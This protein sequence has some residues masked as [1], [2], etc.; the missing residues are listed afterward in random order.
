MTA[1]VIDED[2]WRIWCKNHEVEL[3][4]YQRARGE[5]PEMEC[6]KQLADLVHD[7]Y[8]P[9]AR[10]LDVGCAAGH[11]YRSLKN[12]VDEDIRYT[13]LD[14]T[15]EYIRSAREIFEGESPEFLVGDIFELPESIGTFEVVFCCNLL[16]HLPDFRVPIR[17]LLERTERY[18]FIRTL[19][20]ERTLLA[21]YLY[22]DK[23]DASGAPTNY[24]HQNTYSFD[25][26][27]SYVRS[28]GDYDVQLIDDR[29]DAASIN[30]EY[31]S[32]KDAQAAVT[33]V[34]G[35]QQVSGNLIFE[36]K[37]LR[38]ERL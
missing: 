16:L 36:W 14:A 1:P 8:K 17:N 5:L 6:A 3:R 10:V 33:R 13:G 34:L 20:G 24:V 4:T 25:L 22:E 21:R 35:Q 7:V 26:L 38:I 30:A 18:C 23:F 15:E 11:F 12:R 37:W 19:I 32:H 31:D 28:I 2:R 29:F 9:G 27:D